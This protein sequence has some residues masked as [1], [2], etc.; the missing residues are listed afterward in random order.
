MGWHCGEFADS[1]YLVLVNHCSKAIGLT[2]RTTAI[3]G[4]RNGRS[5]TGDNGL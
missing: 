2:S 4:A 5:R 3:G 1:S